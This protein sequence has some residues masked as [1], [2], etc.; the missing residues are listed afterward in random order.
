MQGKETAANVLSKTFSYIYALGT[1]FIGSI[2]DLLIFA[3][4][5]FYTPA[6]GLMIV[7]YNCYRIFTYKLYI[8]TPPKGSV[9]RFITEDDNPYL[10]QMFAIVAPKG[11]SLR[12]YRSIGLEDEYAVNTEKSVLSIHIEDLSL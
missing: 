5:G 9:H 1:F 11:T 6:F 10:Y 8:Y 4:F 2:G 3:M 7:L 12:I